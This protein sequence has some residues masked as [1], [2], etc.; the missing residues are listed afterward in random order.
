MEVTMKRD[1]E[2]VRA[3]LTKLEEQSPNANALDGDSFPDYDSSVVVYHYSIMEQAGLISARI[4][5]NMDERYWFGLAIA[6]TWQG[7]ELLAN[8]RSDTVWT[9]LKKTVSEKGLALGFDAIK[10][11]ATAYIKSQF[12]N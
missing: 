3:I 9:K 2:L 11:A 1:W 8:I 7:H 6:L 10:A 5:S 4:D 12:D